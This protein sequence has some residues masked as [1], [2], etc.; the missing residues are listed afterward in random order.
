MA[1]PLEVDG[2]VSAADNTGEILA[3]TQSGGQIVEY[4][5]EET[6]R[7]PVIVL[8]YVFRVSYVH[9]VAVVTVRPDADDVSLKGS[10]LVL[11]R[12]PAII[13]YLVGLVLA[14]R[15][16]TGL[17][18]EQAVSAAQFAIIPYLIRHSHPSA[19][20]GIKGIELCIRIA[21]CYEI[22]QQILVAAVNEVHDIRLIG[23]PEFIK[24]HQIYIV[25]ERISGFHMYDV[26]HID[27]V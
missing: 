23:G 5:V 8:E 17:E 27:T 16:G 26:N 7:V 2:E 21:R 20:P 10:V 18:L 24:A 15:Y 4:V 6:H 25:A 14:H 19:V 22:L 12:L 1:Q 9:I 13:T 11:D 3:F